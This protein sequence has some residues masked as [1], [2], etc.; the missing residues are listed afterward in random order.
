MTVAPD[1]QLIYGEGDRQRTQFG[2]TV[3]DAALNAKGERQPLTKPSERPP[4]KP[5]RSCR[6]QLQLAARVVGVARGL[7]DRVRLPIATILSVATLHLREGSRAAGH[8]GIAK[9]VRW[10]LRRLRAGP[11]TAMQLLVCGHLAGLWGEPLHWD[12]QR[13]VLKR[14]PFAA[15]AV[16]A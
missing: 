5:S 15:V 16:P 11:R 3:F 9:A 2:D 8:W 6:R 14:S 4:K 12:D 10:V 13:Q 1:G 7:S